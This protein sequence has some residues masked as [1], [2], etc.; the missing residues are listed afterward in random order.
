MY[1]SMCESEATSGVLTRIVAGK[2]EILQNTEII[3]NF[4]A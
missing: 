1:G 2:T 4:A 3:H